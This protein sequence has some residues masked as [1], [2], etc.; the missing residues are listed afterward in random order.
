M[1][2]E[3]AELSSRL[4]SNGTYTT[5]ISILDPVHFHI[6]WTL[7]V[8]FL[9]VYV[10]TSILSAEP[11]PESKEPVLT[12]PGGKPLPRSARKTREERE[13]KKLKDF[14][15]GRKQFFFYLSIALLGTFIANGTTIVLH[16]L[17]EEGWWCGQSLAV[18]GNPALKY[19]LCAHRS[20][21]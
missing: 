14:S 1:A 2:G 15:P 20:Q 6:A 16:A 17:T 11:S 19:R 9:G 13:R 8:V 7:F 18:S 5:T 12:G 10:A 3:G 21:L 4:W